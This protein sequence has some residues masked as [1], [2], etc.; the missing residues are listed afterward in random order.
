MIN[1]CLQRFVSI[2]DLAIRAK[3]EAYYHGFLNGIFSG[4]SSYLS[5]YRSQTDAGDGYVDIIL[6]SNELKT[7]AVLELKYQI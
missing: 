4:S 3:P 5:I 1:A 7:G 6:G 2:R